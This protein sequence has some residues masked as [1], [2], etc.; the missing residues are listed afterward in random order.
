MRT[1]LN[2]FLLCLMCTCMACSGMHKDKYEVSID[3]KNMPDSVLYVFSESG[4]SLQADTIN[5]SK[6]N[7]FHFETTDKE[8]TLIVLVYGQDDGFI[9][10]YPDKEH[11]IISVE[12]D[13]AYPELVHVNGGALNDSLTL[14]RSGADSLLR[15]YSSYNHKL[16]KAWRG[17][18]ISLA[19]S[20]YQSD[21][22]IQLQRDVYGAVGGYVKQHPASQS[23]L[24][25]IRDYCTMKILPGALDSLLLLPQA[26]LL[27]DPLFLSLKEISRSDS[28]SVKLVQ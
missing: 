1:L 22:Y 14:F 12:G 2:S 15:V 19:D 11:L 24:Y 21:E 9:S 23:S 7:L 28:D 18:S 4:N 13:A 6:D 17:D 27:T 26:P 20:L 16:E 5:I 3:L 10:I 25:L 8:I